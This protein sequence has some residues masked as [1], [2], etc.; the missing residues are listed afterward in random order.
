MEIRFWDIQTY[1]IVS[2]SNKNKIFQAAT[3]AKELL[4]GGISPT[5]DAIA[6]KAAATNNNNNSNNNI[7]PQPLPQL[8][9]SGIYI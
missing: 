4:T 6:K 1:P 3:I 8:P 7:P 5:A 9:T 2:W